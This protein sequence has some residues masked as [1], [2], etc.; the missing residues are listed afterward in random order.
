MDEQKELAN[1]IT[2]LYYKYTEEVS[3]ANFRLSTG[4][5]DFYIQ[6]FLICL[7]IL[8]HRLALPLDFRNLYQTKLSRVV[9]DLRRMG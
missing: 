7:D 1:D 8:K 5:R 3:M 9:S 6:E 4:R 2:A